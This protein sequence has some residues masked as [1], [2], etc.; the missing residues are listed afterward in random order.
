MPNRR[1]VPAAVAEALTNEK[2]SSDEL[3]FFMTIG[4][5]PEANSSIDNQ[6]PPFAS[7]AR[8]AN[9]QKTRGKP[10]V[11]S[12]SDEKLDVQFLQRLFWQRQ[13]IITVDAYAAINDVTGDILRFAQ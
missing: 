12:V 13:F 7:S 9:Q 3:A 6:C 1:S 8:I 11:L 10:R 2:A 4:Q 5:K